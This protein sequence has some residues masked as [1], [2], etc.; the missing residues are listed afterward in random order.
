LAPDQWEH[1]R[2][3]EK[4]LGEQAE[5]IYD[6]ECNPARMIAAQPDIALCVNEFRLAVANCLRAARLKSIPTLLLQDG[7]LEWRCQ[8]ENPL[9]GMG[10]GPPQHQ[11]VLADKIACIGAQSARV[12]RSWGNDGK[13][14]VTG[15]PRLDHLLCRPK[16]QCRKPGR[17][18]LIATAKNPGFTPQQ[19]EISIRSIRDVA[20]QLEARSDVEIGWRVSPDVARQLGIENKLSEF[21]SVDA[22]TAIER[23]DAVVTTPSTLMLEAMLLGR[24]V[25]ALDY[26]NVPHFV[27]TVWNIS[28]HEHILPVIDD[29]LSCPGNKMQYQEH[30]LRDCLACERPAAINVAELIRQMTGREAHV[31]LSATASEVHTDPRDRPTRTA[32]WKGIAALYPEQPL[33]RIQDLAELQAHAARLQKENEHLHKELAA[34]S[35]VNGLFKVGR[36]VSA[37][38]NGGK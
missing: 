13:V 22:A 11:P 5:F 16:A 6:S 1:I 25:A 36:L 33:F 12:L 15:M 35:L 31:G 24:P 21:S 28:A 2:P 17:R 26:H 37:K 18:I 4:A 3:V 34:R 23:A 30:I 10:G 32:E 38:M 14:E 8:Y 27:P 9:F 20:K 29:M 19:R 7:I